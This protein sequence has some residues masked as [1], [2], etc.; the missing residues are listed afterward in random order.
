ME[1][2]EVLGGSSAFGVGLGPLL[3]R[4]EGAS[5]VARDEDDVR[6]IVGEAEAGS[7]AR[8]P[9]QLVRRETAARVQLQIV[10]RA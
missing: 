10:L 7:G 3:V 5:L 1:S 9:H 6:L 4:L 8:R 2:Y